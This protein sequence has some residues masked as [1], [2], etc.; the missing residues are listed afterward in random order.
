MS[1]KKQDSG[2]H[3]HDLRTDHH[4]IMDYMRKNMS[5][6][7]VDEMVKDAYKHPERGRR[8]SA[9]ID[10]ETNEYKLDSTGKIHKAHD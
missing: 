7:L 5:K 3:G 4:G 6:E 9:H 8:F 10:G 2:V 1:D